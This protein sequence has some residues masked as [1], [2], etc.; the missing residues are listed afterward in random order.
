MIEPSRRGFLTGFGAVLITAPAIVRAGSLMPVKVFES[1]MTV[2][3]LLAQHILYNRNSEQETSDRCE[4][5]RIVRDP[6]RL[7]GN[8]LINN[9]FFLPFALLLLGLF[10][11]IWSGKYFYA[12]RR[13]IGAAL[14]GCGW[15][16]GL[17]AWGISA[18]GW[19]L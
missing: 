17:L 14:V 10:L 5:P 9:F 2:E 7:K 1:R 12:D 11:G 3:E 6:L 15:L 13:L 19:L 18:G 8:L 16:C 4:P